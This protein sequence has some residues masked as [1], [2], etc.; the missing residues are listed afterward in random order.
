ML[1][2]L[3]DEFIPGGPGITRSDLQRTPRS[4]SVG[5][6]PVNSRGTIYPCAVSA[7]VIYALD[8]IVRALDWRTI[9]IVCREAD[10]AGHAISGAQIV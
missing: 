3:H 9:V 8:P 7:R 10:L 2:K 6:V 1:S 4:V 5:T